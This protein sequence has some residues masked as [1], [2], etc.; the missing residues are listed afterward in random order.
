LFAEA[1]SS[2]TEQIFAIQY[3]STSM[4]TTSTSSCS[5]NA[6]SF[7]GLL[8][9]TTY[10][11]KIFNTVDDSNKVGDNDGNDNT[12]NTSSASSASASVTKVNIDSIDNTDNTEMLLSCAEQSICL[13]DS[14]SELCI[15]INPT[16]DENIITDGPMYV[17]DTT[18]NVYW[19]DES[20]GNNEFIY[21]STSPDNGCIDSS[22]FY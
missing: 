12:T 16:G 13:I 22:K 21:N 11:V 20:N 18:N 1:A 9:D 17:N 4:T 6:V 8:P 19:I 15:D 3:S 7:M 2:E 10:D 5:G 14:E